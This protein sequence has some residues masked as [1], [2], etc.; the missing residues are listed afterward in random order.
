MFYKT[1][2]KIVCCP[3]KTLKHWNTR[4]AHIACVR[5]K[6]EVGSKTANDGDNV[7]SGPRRWGILVGVN[8]R[9]GEFPYMAALGYRDTNEKNVEVIKYLCGGTLIS[10]QHV[11][12]AAHCVSN[13]QS[14]VPVLVR[15]GNDDL[16]TVIPDP[17]EIPIS[18][19]IIHPEYNLSTYYHDI[20]ILKL[21]KKV[22]RSFLVQP[23]CIQM[24]SL[25]EMNL[26]KNDTLTVT[27]WG[28][29]S[30]YGDGSTKLLKAEELRFVGNDECSKAYTDHRWIP[31]GLDNHMICAIDKNI[32]RGAD[33]CQGDSGGPLLIKSE[34]NLTLVG[35]TSFGQSCGGPSPGVYISVHSYLDWIEKTV[36]SNDTDVV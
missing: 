9:F 12:T 16:G 26:S 4:P 23:I 8:V 1:K 5:Y 28:A 3:L 36:W 17:L 11:L 22:Y 7:A 2:R 27:G 19:I 10:L 24:K 15:L 20:A 32:T 6:N 33:T 29:T 14:R 13:I 31:S 21:E 35:V 34:N 30:V 18:K 25:T